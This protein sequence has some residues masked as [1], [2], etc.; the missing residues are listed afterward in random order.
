MTNHLLYVVGGN[1]AL[2]DFLDGLEPRL[3]TK[4]LRQ[5]AMLRYT[6]ITRLCEPYYKHFSTEKYQKLY[7]M[8]IRSKVLIRIIFTVQGQNTILLIPFVKRKPRDTMQALERSLKLLYDI[9]TAPDR[10]A[11]FKPNL[12]E[13]FK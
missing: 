1:P 12:E 10:V 8:R 13:Q 5:I 7:E 2:Q 3:Q 6:P 11:E 9:K 4:V